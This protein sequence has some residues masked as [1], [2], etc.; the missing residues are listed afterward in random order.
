MTT[1]HPPMPVAS[2]RR[3]GRT[4]VA[5]N[6]AQNRVLKT[7]GV[8]AFDLHGFQDGNRML[9]ASLTLT[10]KIAM[11]RT[12]STSAESATKAMLNAAKDNIEPPPH[13]RLR[14]RDK[15]FWY[16]VIGARA[17][18][19]WTDADLVVASQLARC[20]SDIEIEQLALEEET[21]VIANARG[22]LRVNPRVSVLE[23]YARREMALMRTLRMGGRIA[24]DAR[25][26]AGRRK[27]ERS[28]KQTRQALLD[29]DLL[30]S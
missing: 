27:L 22:T 28:V 7:G 6:R 23:Q 30:A 12:K 21:A 3:R 11:K 17:R 24:G 18:D 29:D 20:Q 10:H 26:E 9:R 16:G 5:D 15:Q 1:N 13:V 25:D 8:R 19:E 2:L 14:P 4:P